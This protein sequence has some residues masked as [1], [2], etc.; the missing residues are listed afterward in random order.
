MGLYVFR[1]MHAFSLHTVS[2]SLIYGLMTSL[3]GIGRR[4]GVDAVV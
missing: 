1:F 2:I 3:V 4:E